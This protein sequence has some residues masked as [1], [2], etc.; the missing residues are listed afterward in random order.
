SAA[1]PN[2]Q[3]RGYGQ[4]KVPCCFECNQRMSVYLEQP[5]K[6][7]IAAGVAAVR[8]MDSTTLFLWLA[9]LYYGTRFY[10]TQLRT[11]VADPTAP[12]MLEHSQLLDRNDYLRRLLLSNPQD[13]K[14]VTPPGTTLVFRAGVPTSL[15]ARFDFFVST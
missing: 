12:A 5:V 10:E 2:G 8:T 9:K 15:Q 11:E 1:L 3:L 6:A 7:S 4:R 13:L 14:F